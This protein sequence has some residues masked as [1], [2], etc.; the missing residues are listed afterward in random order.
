MLHLK[1]LLVNYLNQPFV[2][3]IVHRFS[4]GFW[5]FTHICYGVYLLT[6]DDSGEASKSSEQLEFLN[7]QI[8]TEVDADHYS[9][10]FRPDLLPGMYSTP[11][12]AVPRK[13]NLHL[14]NHQSHGKF[15]L[16][17]MINCNNIARVKLDGIYELGESL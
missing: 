14:G 16:N 10:P 2:D 6:V 9:A 5:P 15:S 7:K 1:D 4:V 12:L 3:S 17:S 8:Q 11:I 13:G